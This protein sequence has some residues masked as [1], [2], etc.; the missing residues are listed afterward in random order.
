[1][2]RFG[3]E[4]QDSGKVLLRLNISSSN[5]E[6]KRKFI[7]KYEQQQASEAMELQRLL[8]EQRLEQI[9][10]EELER[11]ITEKSSARSREPHIIMYRILSLT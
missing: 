7:D 6:R 1:M 2:N 10:K 8:N 11:Q 9:N 4:T 3:F 5:E